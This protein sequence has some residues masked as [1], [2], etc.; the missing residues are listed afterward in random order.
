MYSSPVGA[1]GRG[2]FTGR[3]GMTK[4]VKLGPKFELLATNQLDDDGFDASA[5][6]VGDE[7]YLRG[8]NHLYCIAESKPR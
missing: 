7:L 1:A 5:A 2:Y 4:V 6:L 8:R 3:G